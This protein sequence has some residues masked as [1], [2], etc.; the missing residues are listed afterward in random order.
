MEP[1]LDLSQNLAEDVLEELWFGDD[2][3]DRSRQE[4]S[5]SLAASAAKAAGLKPFP[6]VAAKVLG[7]LEEPK[8]DIRKLR[9]EIEVDPA[10]AGRLIRVA[11]SPVFRPMSPYSSLDAVVMRL[12]TQNVAEIV[13][14]IATV[15]MFEDVSGLG[16]QIRNHCTGAAA[17]GRVLGAE[18]RR[19]GVSSLFLAT[20]MHDLGKLLS[21]QT[22]EISYETMDPELFDQPNRVHIAE[23]QLVGY[24]H[25]ILGA[26]V[27]DRWDFP[28][29]LCRIVGWHHNPGRAYEH[30]GDIGLVVALLRLADKIEYQMTRNL[31]VDPLFIEEL[32]EQGEAAY[33][34]YSRELLMGLWP[35]LVAARA[36]IADSLLA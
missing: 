29:A 7:L 1:A 6:A 18:W 31:E 4:A 17:I 3:P 11:N 23:R 20:L 13:A 36:E 33:A 14:A 15:S 5:Q 12:G 9:A 16:M 8:V 21:I 2:D 26:H 27:L 28:Q 32:A 30:G 19:G 10:L 35:K 34:D 25:A 24:D 22:G